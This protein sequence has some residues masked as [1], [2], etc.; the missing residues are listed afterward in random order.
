MFPMKEQY[1]TQEE[2]VNEVEI[3]DLYN[4]EFKVIKMLI[5]IIKMLK[6]LR[7]RMAEHRILIKS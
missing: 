4:K 2:E 5:K 3:S 7:R 6:E 1:K